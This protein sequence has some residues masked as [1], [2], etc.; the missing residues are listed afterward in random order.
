MQKSFI[1]SERIVGRVFSHD[2]KVNTV[3]KQGDNFGKEFISGKVYIAID[4]EA[5][6]VVDVRY[7]FITPL[8]KKGTPNRTYQVLKKIMDGPTWSTAG[9]DVAPIV[10]ATP[11]IDTNDFYLVSE[12]RIIENV[13]NSQGFISISNLAALEKARKDGK[14]HRFDTDIVIT[15]TI[16][17]EADPENNVPE[18]SVIVRGAVFGYGPK[19]IPVSYVVKT[20]DGMN[21]FESLEASNSNPVY[22]KVWGEINNVTIAEKK[23]VASAFGA[24]S[25]EEKNRKVKEYKITGA[26][27]EPYIFNDETTITADDLKK[28]IQDREIHL[29]NVKTDAIARS[30]AQSSTNINIVTPKARDFTF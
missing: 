3:K 30:Q 12:D 29:A 7:G 4:D 23:E 13:V 17:R 26:S 9:K 2:L 19:L 8:T 27:P 6:N 1:N 24:P 22:T 11:T 25:I 14:S 10:E 21:Y 16:R 5:T 18:D 15:S 20:T 28:L